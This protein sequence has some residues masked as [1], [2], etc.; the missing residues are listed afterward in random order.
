MQLRPLRKERPGAD[1]RDNYGIACNNYDHDNTPSNYSSCKSSTG[2][3]L[4]AVF[5]FFFMLIL[6][7]KFGTYWVISR[8]ITTSP[9]FVL[10]AIGAIIGIILAYHEMKRRRLG[11]EKKHTLLSSI[12]IYLFLIAFA[13]IFY[14]F[15]PWSW[16]EYPDLSSRILAMF[17]FSKAGMVFYGG[18]IG[19]VAGIFIYSRIKKLDFWELADIWAPSGGIILFFGRIGCYTAGCCY[20]LES[21][22]NL[23]WLILRGD[24][25]MHP[26]Q[27]YS[28]ILGIMVFILMTELKYRQT[29]G[30]LFNGYV[31]LWGVIF[32]S[33]GRFFIEFLRYYDIRFLGLSSS[34]FISLGLVILCSIA[35]FFMYSGHKAHKHLKPPKYL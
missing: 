30:K 24:T 3:Y 5:N 35:L 21:H 32:Y 23:P 6:Y 34:Q 29:A 31:V 25:V 2:K 26:T 7:K 20:G 9:Y 28:S 18:M 1:S 17:S 12:T 22:A 10:A 14:F 16:K 11:D 19:A 15:G 13:R 27:I 4:R 8:E 33:I